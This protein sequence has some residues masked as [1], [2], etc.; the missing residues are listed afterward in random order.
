MRPAE[1][2]PGLETQWPPRS[3]KEAL[4][5]TPGGRERYRQM[6]AQR[7]TSPSPLRHRASTDIMYGGDPMD[8]DDDGDDEE[9]L[10][11]KLQEIQAQ[12]KL[13]KLRKEKARLSTGSQGSFSQSAEDLGRNTRTDS[14]A[15]ALSGM[16]IKEIRRTDPAVR[17]NQQAQVEVPASPVRKTQSQQ[18]TTH[19][20]PSRVSLG[21]DKGL[22]AADISLKR[23]PSLRK[24][25]ETP[26]L[27]GSQNGGYLRTSRSFGSFDEVRKPLSFSER[28]KNAREEENVREEKRST[29]S[30]S[31][32]TAFNV[33]RQEM[34]NY[35][36]NAT[37]ILDDAPPT[38]RTFTKDEILGRVPSDNNDAQASFTSTTSEPQRA[39]SSAS[40][41]P[42]SCFHL[43]KRILPHQVVARAISG[44]TTYSLQDLLRQIK[45]PDWSLP[46]DVVD[47]VVFAMVATKSEPR[48]HKSQYD[49]ETGKMKAPDRGKY[50]V[51]TLVDLQYEIELFLFNSGFERFWKLTTG[52][53]VAILNP[54]IMPPP[55]GKRDTGRFSLAINS[56]CD[57]ILEIGMARDIGYCKSIKADGS[58]CNTWVNARRTEYCDFHTNSALAKNRGARME[59][60]SGSGFGT[61]QK[62]GRYSNSDQKANAERRAQVAETHG[63]FD[64]DSGGRYF[65]SGGGRGF[66]SHE[67]DA[68]ANLAETRERAEAL[69]RRLAVKEKE[70][71]IA[72]KLGDM[73]GNGMG[74]QY[75]RIA[76][77]SEPSS[78]PIRT[79]RFGN[80][81]PATNGM[82]PPTAA[83][84][85]PALNMPRMALPGTYR[86]H[87]TDEQ[88]ADEQRV[89]ARSLGLIAPR[90]SQSKI[91]LSPIKRKRQD[92]TQ[93]SFT[94]S[95]DA[96]AG[97]ADPSS[98]RAPASSSS[99]SSSRT[100]G[101]GGSLRDK[102]ARM[103]DGER[104]NLNLHAK[105]DSTSTVASA[106]RDKD[107][108]PVRKKTRFVT[109]KGIRE[110][111]RESLPGG[112]LG[113]RN[114]RPGVKG[115]Y[116]RNGGSFMRGRE[117]VLDEDEDMD[118]LVVVR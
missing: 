36:S 77:N 6:L 100:Y 72:K 3:P 80:G 52:T 85:S 73:N 50:M 4:L 23:A 29:A 111:G 94:A 79:S 83:R 76:G 19:T 26:S 28:L 70:R 46:D 110:A 96:A 68:A 75:M 103:R 61:R 105:K 89:D 81:R 47:S 107:R 16:R 82:A 54:D 41:E 57:T 25:T 117:V 108:S 49:P 106:F 42:Y 101:W 37:D 7:T 102:L 69:K 67:Q 112:A 63:S 31:R 39:T 27:A 20:S 1:P 74:G 40:F 51:L 43:S 33:G 65:V 109:D 17:P 24:S 60:N 90:G 114:S 8:L 78:A 48:N 12:L 15:T 116:S 32:S 62:H 71:D 97:A 11:L 56:D 18:Q 38:E 59:V 87:D 9:T 35:K 92:S 118:E 95:F 44:K 21:I 2:A 91:S 5:S 104:L 30:R 115:L 84:F 58:L 53:V 34:E 93:S 88:D 66:N 10:Q 14:A 86:P 55:P 22:K 99:S 98:S 13:K 113:E 64:R 45:A